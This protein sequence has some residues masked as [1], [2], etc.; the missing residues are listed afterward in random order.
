MTSNPI[1]P[2][3][4]S[5]NSL[6]KEKVK[7]WE[8]Q[9]CDERFEDPASRKTDRQTIFLSYAH[10][11]ERP[12]DYDISQDLV[13]LVKE[14]L[15]KDG[16]Q[17]W[18]D[19]EGI[20]GGT[21]WRERITDAITTHKHF[22]AFL[23]RR[24]VRQEP[25][26]CLNEV[27]IAIKHNRII[28]TIL[29]EKES[30][31]SPPLT[32]SSIQWHQFSEW[33]A[34]REGHKTGPQGENWDVWFSNL[35]AS[36]RQSLADITHQKAVGELA[37]LKEIL[38][39]TSF[40][41]A[42]IHG[43]E[44]FFGRRWLFDAFNDWLQSDNRIFWLKGTPGIGKSSFA[45][46]LV[47]SGESS[48]V[49]FFKCDFQAQKSAEESAN[50][51]IRTLAY[52]LASRLPDYRIKLL[53]GQQVDSET[54]QKKTADDLFAYLITEPLNRSEKIAEDQRLTLVIDAL[55]EAGRQVNGKMAN[56]LAD[57]LYKHA[58]QMPPWLGILLTSR[59]EAYLQQQLGTKF[60]PFIIE[61]GAKD[62]LSDIKEYL[63][64]KLDPAI[65]GEQREKTVQALI[66]KSGGTFL[67]VRRVEG[68]Y[69][70]SRPEALPDGLDDLFY[71]D[72]ER[73]FPD[74]EKYEEKTEKFLRLLACAPGPL[75]KQLAQALLGWPARDV[76]QYV[77]QPMASLLSESEEGLQ[78]F[79]KSIQDWLQDGARS[80]IYQVN[81]TG[82]IEL[83][84]FLW[85]E[86]EKET[87][88]KGADGTAWGSLVL[89]WLTGLL[90]GTK[91]WNSVGDLDRFERYLEEHQK[92]Y[93]QLSIQR[94]LL[95]LTYAQHGQQSQAY[96]E[97][98]T[99]L[100]EMLGYTGQYPAALEALSEA[101]NI[102][103]QTAGAATLQSASAMNALAEIWFALADY[104]KAEKLYSEALAI[105]EKLLG[106]RHPETARSMADLAG[107]L[108]SISRFDPA[109]VLYRDALSVMQ[110]C[111]GPNDPV[112]ALYTTFLAGIYEEKGDY[113][114]SEKLFRHA[115]EINR[116]LLPES[117]PALS[118][119]IGYVGWTLAS[120]GEFS[121]AE[122]CYHEALA[123]QKSVLGSE[124]PHTAR[125]LTYLGDTRLQQ[126]DLR[127][128]D[129]HYQQSLS[130]RK[131]IFG[132]HHPDTARTLMSVAWL[133]QL[134]GEIAT[135]GDMYSHALKVFEDT[136]G[137]DYPDTGNAMNHLGS[138]YLRYQDDA[139]QAKNLLGQSVRM[140][141]R[142][143][144]MDHPYTLRTLAHHAQ[145][146]LA[147]GDVDG[148]IQA[149]ALVVAKRRAVLGASHPD[150]ILAAGSLSWVESAMKN[151]DP[152]S[153]S[154]R[155]MPNPNSLRLAVR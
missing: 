42:I 16:H 13:W 116:M 4:A 40:D 85:N 43:V 127:S 132:D 63:N 48:V 118:L 106:R 25:N 30:K 123:I 140:H 98:L 59:P 19:Q 96:A 22:L 36:V 15:E 17:V 77:T 67:Y 74:P 65:T 94:R 56:P 149:L 151:G 45:A 88:S 83:G 99:R 55:D 20:R 136:C 155:D 122:A 119:S 143:L 114:E 134:N 31:V 8:C 58:D 73:Y 27:A 142:V 95:D 50:E 38:R 75:P 131:I 121:A 35:M 44:G 105:R 51:C 26:V 137:P 103:E 145:L 10:K 3:C 46:K 139:S 86:F 135:A 21:Q 153:A 32:L 78:F 130:L 37:E 125:T 6:F 33:K 1:C 2:Y 100:G 102:Y 113:K 110:A 112:T 23:S 29:T 60:S 76:S 87:A 93:F 57:L 101:V 115:L 104:D 89:N 34:I 111:H 9:D 81:D 24:S 129:T 52:Q 18:I 109:Q 72:F 84:E 41:A 12:D 150:S 152:D 53:R 117:D 107:L 47:H 80:G 70:L 11:S 120:K 126:G 14:E 124:H 147:L 64:T 54:V 62:N 68:A 146:L 28:Q 82:A 66:D 49:G 128:A 71:R 39:P 133:S 154:W 90:A 141:Q 7:R 92:F 61:G 91:A 97:R 79:H 108:Q 69:D 144:G 138:W 5:A 148:A